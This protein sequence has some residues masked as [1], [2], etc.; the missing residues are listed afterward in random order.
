MMTAALSYLRRPVFSTSSRRAMIIST[1]FLVARRCYHRSFA[2]RNDNDDSEQ[3][4]ILI[5]HIGS[6]DGINDRMITKLT[7]NRPKANAM[8]STMINQ[9]QDCLTSLEK[10][11]TDMADQTDS[12]PRCVVITSFSD[13]VFS[14]GADL[15]ERSTMTQEE[16]AE[17]VTTLRNTM[18][19][20][21][22]LPMPVIA[23]LEGVAV[24]G[25][26]ELAL[27]ADLRVA[28]PEAAFGLPETTLAIL[29]GAGGTQR[30][31]RLI[32][33]SK[34]KELIWTGRRLQG[35]EAYKY[36]L[37]D[38][39]VPAGEATQKSIDLAQQISAN[40]PI[41]IRA[42]KEAIDKGLTVSKMDDALEIERQCYAKVLPTNDR[43][44]G[45]AAFK[46]GRKPE[47]TG[48]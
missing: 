39:L 31:P 17:F 3:K 35:E 12:S 46:E 42:S 23:A 44:E 41:A 15:K 34:A 22:K 2:P 33:T 43:L 37:I 28:T 9:L 11:A 13:R 6:S 26:L 29:P 45:L 18:E 8:G 21:A 5:E 14:A 4:Q 30:L 7:L 1:T 38:I 16:A 27:A 19:R 48:Q 24:G 40:G 47:Y 10:D 32:G 25:G 36:G 20:I